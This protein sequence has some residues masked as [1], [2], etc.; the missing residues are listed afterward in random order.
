MQALDAYQRRHSWL[1]FAIA[2]IYKYV[3]D[4]GGYMAALVTYYGFLSLFPLLLLTVTIL[5]F[6]LHGDPHLQTRLLNSTLARFPLIGPQLRAN[7]HAHGG[8]GVGL[9]VGVLV[10]L[11]G[12]LGA[13]QATQYVFNRVWS[14]PLSQ[15]PS[16]LKARLRSLLVLLVFGLGVLLTSALSALGTSSGALGATLSGGLRVLLFLLAFLVNLAESMFVFRL[17]TAPEIPTRAL[18]LGAIVAGVALQVMQAVGSLYLAHYLKGASESYG[19]FGLVL[20]LIAWIYLLAL[21]LVLSVEIDVVATR[22]L[23]PRP[24]VQTGGESASN[25]ERPRIGSAGP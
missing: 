24:L 13:A 12:S 22:G 10:A 23:W 19:A 11:Y 16:A 18:R 20:G 5:G 15:R 17:L 2:V 6:V 8:S 9:A 7:V 25:E 3:D 4:K 1:G 14:V 21:V